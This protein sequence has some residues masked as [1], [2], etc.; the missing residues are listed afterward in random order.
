MTRCVGGRSPALAR[1]DALTLAQ[2]ASLARS[3]ARSP[4]D[5]RR[6]SQIGVH[7]TG[8]GPRALRRGPG[9]REGRPHRASGAL[10][11]ETSRSFRVDLAR[12]IVSHIPCILQYFDFLLALHS[13]PHRSHRSLHYSYCTPPQFPFPSMLPVFT[14]SVSGASTALASPVRPCRTP[15]LAVTKSRGAI[16]PSS[17][18]FCAARM[19]LSTHALTHSRTLAPPGSTAARP[20][21][22]AAAAESFEYEAKVDSLMQLVGIDSGRRC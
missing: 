19:A 9:P 8:G 20:V 12:F 4:A 17:R 2:C 18:S 16:A 3:L 6:E 11:S 13:S 10:A 15:Q 5:G 7:D 21:V 14:S 1:P 22:R